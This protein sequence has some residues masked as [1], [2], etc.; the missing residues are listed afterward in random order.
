M[1]K[2]KSEQ[3]FFKST[4]NYSLGILGTKVILFALVPFLSFFLEAKELGY[5]DLI[6]ISITLIT[7]LITLQISDAA[8]RFLLDADTDKNRGAI[9]SSS[10]SII[11]IGYLLIIPVAILVGNTLNF[12][13][14][15][16]FLILQLSNCVFFFVLQIT[17]GLGRNKLYALTGA[18]NTIFIILFSFSL[19]LFLEIN[20]KNILYCLFS[21]QMLSTFIVL[22]KSKIYKYLNIRYVEL[23][24]SKKMIS[25]S[26]P[27]LPNSISWWLIDLGNRYI[28]LFFLSEESNGI[29]AISARYAGIIA[30]FNS[31]FILTWQD[32]AI[33]DKESES[34]R[35]KKNSKIFEQYLIFE[36]SLIL[37]LCA[38]SKYLI[39]FTTGENFI[40]AANYLPILFLSAGF[41]SFCGFYGA[42]YLREKHTFGVFLTTLL[43][44]VFN[45]FFSIYFIKDFGLYAVA[46][47]SLIGFIV[48]LILRMIKFKLTVNI[49]IFIVGI[50]LFLMVLFV[51][52]L[53]YFPLV[54][55]SI[56]FLIALFILVN[57]ELLLKVLGF[58]KKIKIKI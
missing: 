23:E 9:L 22:F 41:S 36:F 6:L 18:L 4:L 33:S 21:A 55:F 30:L 42:F 8:Y 39:E 16:E 2:I 27:L 20:L 44:G 50:S 7:P 14:T 48:T 26:W 52:Y 37:L 3:S 38:I 43:G 1:E 13:F 53:A 24:L 45:I 46:I 25:Y 40:E 15:V 56:V 10:V 12:E 28:I 34:D 17:R 49:Y 31:I 11:F 29:Y 58:I 35:I 47:G 32:K 5:Y 19:L 51:Q 57:K 54:I